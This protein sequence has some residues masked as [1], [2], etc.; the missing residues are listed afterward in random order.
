MNGSQ[1]TFGVGGFVD[2]EEFLSHF[3]I[4]QFVAK[5]GG[6]TGDKSRL[7]IQGTFK[8]QRA[9][10]IQIIHVGIQTEFIRTVVKV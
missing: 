4:G 6:C 7:S 3:P 1:V 10:E 5:I 8:K 2:L 9:T